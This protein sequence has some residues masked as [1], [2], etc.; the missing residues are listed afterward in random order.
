MKPLKNS[1]LRA[2]ILIVLVACVFVTLNAMKKA[3]PQQV[4][5]ALFV[6]YYVEGEATEAE[7]YRLV[8][9]GLPACNSGTD[10]ICQILAPK[11]ADNLPDMHAPASEG[12]V[13]DEIEKALKSIEDG[14]AI[15]NKTVLAFRSE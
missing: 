9:N 15:I 11:N 10:V 7:N 13:I 8:P 5:P 14:K 3:V 12:S 1:W 4:E 6:W 2:S